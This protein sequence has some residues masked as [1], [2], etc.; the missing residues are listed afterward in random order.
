MA[1]QQPKPASNRPK[2][3]RPAKTETMLKLLRREN[4]AS[5][6]QLR[7]ATGRQ[8]HSVRAALERTRE[9]GDRGRPIEGRDVALAA[10]RALG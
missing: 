7:E 6:A 8:P 9:A 5:M 2:K 10:S 1:T 3:R 4:G